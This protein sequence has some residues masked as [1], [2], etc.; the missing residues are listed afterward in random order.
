MAEHYGSALALCDG[1]LEEAE[2][3]AE[4]SHERGRLLSGRDASSVYGIQ[5]FSVS[6]EQGRLAELAPVIAVL[7]AEDRRGAVVA[8]GAYRRC[9]PSW[10]G[11]QASAASSTESQAEGLA[12]FANRSGSPRSPT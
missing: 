5:M 6:R 7:A 11:E 4:R 10:D 9:W 2:A 3:L 1:R 8:T 12:R